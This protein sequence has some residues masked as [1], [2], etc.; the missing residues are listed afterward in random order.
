MEKEAA[1]SPSSR[2]RDSPG[3]GKVHLR[4]LAFNMIEETDSYLA[5]SSGAETPCIYSVFILSPT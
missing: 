4:D 1:L 3:K 5:S 2:K